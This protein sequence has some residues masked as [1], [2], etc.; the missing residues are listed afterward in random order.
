MVTRRTVLEAGSG[1][2]PVSLAGCLD[3]SRERTD[4]G[5]T[6]VVSTFFTFYDF[7]RHVA[8]DTAQ[9][10][11]LVPLGEQGHGWEP[12]ADVQRQANN[13]DVFVYV[14]PGVQRW[15]DNVVTNLRSD[16][17][18][19]VIVNA[20]EG[21]DLLP[22]TETEQGSRETDPHFWLD[23]TLAKHAVTDVRNGLQGADAAND[24]TYRD[25]TE[26]YLDRLN[27]V[28]QTFTDG[29]ASRR[30]NTV[31]VAGHN[32]YRYMANRYNF[33]IFSPIGV[34]PD[35]APSPRAIQQ[36]QQIVDEHDIE[37][38]L[39]PALESDRL[40]RELAQ[41]TDAELLTIT[42]VAGQTDEWMDKDWGYVEQMLN[43]NLV[44][45]KTAL[46]AR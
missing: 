36:V 5:E 18:D 27:D 16:N 46:E 32:A 8:G 39:T 29:L 2:L 20:S 4:T 11:S 14:G 15:A 45:L 43:V 3:G 34:T 22:A 10:E 35:A 1:L 13:A 44:S 25:N 38:I 6:R 37:Y 7:A 19:V 33:E 31:V 21:I 9:V 26:T 23:P 30:K 42:A 17:P 28:D 41:E 40:A 24:T 12:S